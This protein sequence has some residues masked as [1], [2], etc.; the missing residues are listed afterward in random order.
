MET[1]LPISKTSSDRSS[2]GNVE[3][4]GPLPRR[5]EQTGA[6]N[7]PADASLRTTRRWASPGLLRTLAEP[8]GHHPAVHE[9]VRNLGSGGAPAEFTMT[10]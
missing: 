7:A 5:K 6:L 3:V 9:L 4:L 1:S 2:I 8:D 10:E